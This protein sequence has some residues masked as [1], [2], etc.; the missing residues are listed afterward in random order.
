MGS[1]FGTYSVAYS[2]MYVN[3]AALATT[4]NN[5]ANVNTTG[6]S[7]VQLVS[8]EKNT[9]QSSGTSTGDG[10]SV[11]SITRSRDIFLDST[12]RTQN[13]KAT[14]SSVKSGNLEYMD[15]LLCEYETTT[16]TTDDTTVTI[17]GL[18]D[19]ID[20]FYDAWET[21]S[22]ESSSETARA[23]PLQRLGLS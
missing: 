4:S 22:T 16:S 23:A 21:L 15:T 20:A 3:Q 6:A 8:A 19:T 9:V 7:K 14:Y 17:P 10:V 2:G 13:A 11:A 12:Y 1:T 5:L 18:Q